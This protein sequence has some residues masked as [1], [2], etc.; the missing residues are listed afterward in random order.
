MLANQEVTVRTSAD[1]KSG[2]YRCQASTDNRAEHL[3]II[4]EVLGDNWNDRIGM[5]TTLE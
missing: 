3:V 2:N 5:S 4:E 1:V